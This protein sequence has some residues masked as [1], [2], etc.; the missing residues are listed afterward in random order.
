MENLKNLGKS[1]SKNEQKLVHGGISLNGPFVGSSCL[2]MGKCLSDDEC[3][4]R[5][6]GRNICRVPQGRK[7][8]LDV[9][10]PLD[11]IGCGTCVN[12]YGF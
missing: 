10:P 12:R 2:E 11:G 1:L 7:R 5:T 9:G 4:S 8:I 3:S 6:D